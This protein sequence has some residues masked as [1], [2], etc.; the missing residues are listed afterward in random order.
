MSGLPEHHPDISYE[1]V[2]SYTLRTAIWRGGSERPLLFFNGIG[3]NLELIAPLA[4]QF[5]DRDVI[6][7]DMP[8]IGGSPAPTLPY[9]SW[10]M[11]RAAS[12]ILDRNGYGIVDVM[13]VSW[14][15]AMA[16]QFAFQHGGRVGKLILAATSAGMVMIPGEPATLAKL[17]SPRRYMDT[18]YMMRNFE[19]LYG[20]EDDD[21]DDYSLGLKAPT[22]RGYFYQMLAMA[23][24]TSVPFLPF[25][26]Q[27]TLV[28]MGDRDK[29]VPV[30]NG[31]ILE[32]L[33]PN[34]RLYIVEN[35]GHLFLVSRVDESMTVLEEFLAEDDW[36][37][38][39]SR[40]A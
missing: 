15:G 1:K 20:D 33:I 25:L 24:W 6:T 8:G 23:G 40:A 16:Q 7:F 29:I 34:A 13:G 27:K 39:K 3:A 35:G 30:A 11:A 12:K 18:E 28:M 17:G 26:K 19:S 37:K 14:G 5:K 2:G 38:V 31:K 21:A 22:L 10:Q 4:S 32:S 9:R 36:L